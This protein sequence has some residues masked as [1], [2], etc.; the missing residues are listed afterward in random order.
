MI[1]AEARALLEVYARAWPAIVRAFLFQA[2]LPPQERADYLDAVYHGLGSVDLSR[3]VLA[4]SSHL[5]VVTLP[6]EAGW[7]DLGT[8][9]R[10]STWL[11]SV[12]RERATVAATPPRCGPACARAHGPALLRTGSTS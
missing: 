1:V 4:R 12:D 3:D 11:S 5:S 8:E 2:W 9:E 7:S 10:M 6:R